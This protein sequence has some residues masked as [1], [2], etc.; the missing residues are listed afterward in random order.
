[1]P[2]SS[3]AEDRSA[4]ER[5][6]TSCESLVSSF[7]ED[8]ESRNGELN[9]YLHVGADEA[10]QR[11][12]TLD[13]EIASGLWRPLTGL[14]LGVKDVICVKG[15]QTTCGSRMLESFESLFTA[16][17]V[18]RLVEA[19][20]IVIGKL[21]CDEFAMGSSNENSYFGPV[22]NPAHPDYV[23]GG[24]SGGSAAAVAA[25]LCHVALGTDTGGSIR[26]PASLSGVVGLKP[27]YGRVSRFGLV[28][29]ASSFDVIGP[30]ANSV[31]DCAA[32]LKVMA[33]H[34]KRDSTSAPVEVPAYDGSANGDLSGM[35][36]GLPEEYL[37][38][39][40]DDG[41]RVIFDET[42]EVLQQKGAK[43][44][45]VS[46][47]HTRFGI[48][49]YYILATAEA[50]SNLARYDGVRYGY[51]ADESSVRAELDDETR[52]LE[53]AV[54]E[55]RAGGDERQVDE[56]VDQLDGLDSPLQRLYSQ[57]RSEGF[58]PE[59]RRRIMLGT[60]VLSSGYY[61]AYYG[62]AQRVRRLISDDFKAAF[63]QV[64]AL[65]TPATPTPG[66]K[67]GEKID[68]PLEMYLS[69]VYTVTANLAG[70]PGLVVPA[71]SHPGP[72]VLPV[73]LQLLGGPFSEQRLFK[74]GA[75]IAQGRPSNNA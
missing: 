52:T 65:L 28:A 51:R 9:A 66:F 11:A 45:P 32:V 7:L 13:D 68:D 20:A 41:I 17:A 49:T 56:L 6:E 37:Q 19:G 42:V 31:E 53:L 29:Y 15:V 50:S 59:V 57:T 22:R 74:I 54:E 24:S 64:D 43:I 21:N 36:I 72:P 71:G 34:D 2:R 48:A 38:E 18:D 10:L 14:V 3:Y 8:I 60:Y 23:P 58:G 44:Q 16:T 30:M 70:I 12:G 46:L 39:G 67:I 26:Q 61:D 55:A 63:E 25:G 47:P 5:N 62:R 27:T 4:L 1:M 40:L 73:G 35:L 33:G 69:D 75:E